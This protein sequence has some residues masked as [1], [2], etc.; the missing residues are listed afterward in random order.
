VARRFV[1][2]R[3]E[4]TRAEIAGAILHDVG[5]AHCGLGTFGRV[6]ATIVGPR[7]PSFATYLDHEAIGAD[8][9]RRAGSD[10]ATVDLIAQRGP[11]FP[12]L[13]ASDHA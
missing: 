5:K 12:A 6:V 8:L 9:A 3:P 10:P 1:A 13:D 7:N 4:A 11:A 2:A